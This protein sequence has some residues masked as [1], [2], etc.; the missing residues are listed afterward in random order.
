MPP[1]TSEEL[2]HRTLE[3]AERGCLITNSVKAPIQLEA[4]I[5][6]YEPA[7]VA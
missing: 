5:E 2:V 3:K 6:R 7:H 4:T 1:G